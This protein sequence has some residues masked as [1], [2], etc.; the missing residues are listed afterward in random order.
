MSNSLTEV[1][2]DGNITLDLAEAM[3]PGNDAKSWVVTLRKGVTFH[4]GK[5]LTPDDIIASYRHHMSAE[6][7]SAVKSLLA[8]VSDIKDV[9][10][11]AVQ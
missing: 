11:P 6:S 4:N 10:Q 7:K 8:A 1:D 2:A 9:G 3:E 5:D